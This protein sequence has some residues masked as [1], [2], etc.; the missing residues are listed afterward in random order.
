MRSFARLLCCA[1]LVAFACVVPDVELVHS[2]PGAGGS[3]AGEE[4]AGGSSTI[5][6]TAGSSTEQGG[7]ATAAG[8]PP[9]EGGAPD[10][11][12]GG[13]SNG[14][15]GQSGEEL[16]NSAPSCKGLSRTECHG[17]SCCT[18]P[19]VPACNGC[20][21]ANG[22]KVSAAEFRLDK[23]EVTVGRFRAFVKAYTGPPKA[24]S[25]Q[26]PH[27]DS[28]GWQ[29]TWDGNIAASASKLE[30][31]MEL[32]PCKNLDVRTWT[33]APDVG[34]QKPINCLSW[35]EAFAFCAW[36]G[37]FLPSELQW[38]L[39]ATAGAEARTYPWPG[40]NLDTDHALYGAC[41]NGVSTACDLTS[42]LEV[43]SKPAG[44]GK[45]GQLDLAGSVWEWLLDTTSGSFP[46]ADPCNDCANLEPNGGHHIAGGSWVE[47]GS[48]LPAAQRLGDPSDSIWYNVGIRC[49]RQ[50]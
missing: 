27:I 3:A 26:Q 23:Y 50:P 47:D 1:G 10:P 41:G 4:T 40:G 46:G 34:E 12:V 49:A 8:A 13:A 14:A 29:P 7:S 24:G 22:V 37:G 31:D 30:S 6:G 15:A 44:A 42:I 28:S 35:Y 18:S 45:W 21:A 43:G 48:Y 39:A 33:K 2:F 32:R 9:S 5:A 17:E 36:D 19:I 38:H 16:D 11:A 25:G 20:V